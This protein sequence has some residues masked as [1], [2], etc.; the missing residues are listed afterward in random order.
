MKRKHVLTLIIIFVIAQI[1]SFS[2]QEKVDYEMVSKIWEEGI[3]RSQAMR[4]LSYL[5]DVLGP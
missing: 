2:V 1:P 3:N 5:T 4:I